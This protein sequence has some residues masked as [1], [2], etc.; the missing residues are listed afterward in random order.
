MSTEID[1]KRND[2]APSIRMQLQED[3]GTPINISAALRVDLHIKKPSAQ[4]ALIEDR[5]LAIEDA[6]IG[7]VRYDVQTG[8]LD[9]TGRFNVEAEIWWTAI[10]NQ[11][12][13]NKGYSV[14]T[15]QEDLG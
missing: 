12:V 11:T 8:D 15:L 13:P 4:T 1:M 2:T 5:T 14:L 3:D 6:E 7:I 9:S 10:T